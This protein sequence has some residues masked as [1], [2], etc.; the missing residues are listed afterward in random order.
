MKLRQS[1]FREF[2]VKPPFQS[3]K[4]IFASVKILMGNIESE[5]IYYR[6]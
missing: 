6:E 1:L 2:K 3:V 4:D 5:L